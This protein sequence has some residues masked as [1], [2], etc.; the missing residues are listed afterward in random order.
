[1][2]FGTEVGISNDPDETKQR[3]KKTYTETWGNSQKGMPIF[4]MREVEFHLQK[5]EKSG[6]RN[7]GP[8]SKSLPIKKT[9]NHGTKF[10][11]ERYLSADYI[12]ARLKGDQFQ[13]KG[14]YRANMS[15]REVHNVEV[16]FNQTTGIAQTAHCTS[17]AGKSQYCNHVMAL[18]IELAD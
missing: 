15:K 9:L 11:Q 1:M 5:S 4:T 8:N 17:K 18:L 6:K 12:F 2:A 16:F 14:K 7:P 10:K 13:V 3:N